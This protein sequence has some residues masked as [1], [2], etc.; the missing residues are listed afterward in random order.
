MGSIFTDCKDFLCFYII[1]SE[2]I[3]IIQS[4]LEIIFI[5]LIPETY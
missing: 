3:V 1:D 4:V 2:L 5:V